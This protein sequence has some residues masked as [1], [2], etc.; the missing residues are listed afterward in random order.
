MEDIPAY[1]GLS[2]EDLEKE[3]SPEEIQ[4][5]E[6]IEKQNAP[7]EAIRIADLQALDKTRGRALQFLSVVAA[8][9]R[10][11]EVEDEEEL[12]PPAKRARRQSPREESPVEKRAADME[13]ARQNGWA[14][15]DVEE[16][17]NRVRRNFSMKRHKSPREPRETALRHAPIEIA[18]QNGWASVAEE[19]LANQA[20]RAF[21]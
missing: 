1:T 6:T 19:D 20:R 18:R 12:Q 5:A 14:Y 17:R 2:E 9:V 4:H 21:L 7:A 15:I 16:I 13:T 3:M 11:A 8:A 10:E